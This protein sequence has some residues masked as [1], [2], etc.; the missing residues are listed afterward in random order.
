MEV[1]AGAAGEWLPKMTKC[2]V[3]GGSNPLICGI[4]DA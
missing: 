1:E 4:P 2:S 3:S